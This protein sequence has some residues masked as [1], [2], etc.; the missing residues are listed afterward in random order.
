MIHILC[1]REKEIKKKINHG[2]VNL[3]RKKNEKKIQAT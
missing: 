2:A 3:N 1:Q